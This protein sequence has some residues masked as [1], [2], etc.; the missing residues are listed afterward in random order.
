MKTKNLLFFVFAV[1]AGFSCTGV[2]N[3][4]GT[5]SKSDNGRSTATT[6]TSK[7]GDY[8]SSGSTTDSS[9]RR[10]VS[11]SSYTPVISATE[12]RNSETYRKDYGRLADTKT[13]NSVPVISGNVDYN[14]KLIALYT[15]MDKMADVVL[16]ELDITERR[17]NMLLEKYK[18]SNANDRDMISRDLDKLT[19]DQLTLYKAYTN[20]YKNG[21]SDW[22]RVKSE[23][24]STLMNLRG[25]DKK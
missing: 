21:K 17:W 11:K 22:P 12:T 9:Y 1:Y 15:E 2:K 16:Y 14:Q 18:T 13:E 5:L 24:E 3:M 4:S 8:L 10:P 7:H 19:A 20:I 23:V 6:T 25:F